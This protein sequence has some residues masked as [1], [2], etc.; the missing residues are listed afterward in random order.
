[1]LAVSMTWRCRE[2]RLIDDGPEPGVIVTTSRSCT[3]LPVADDGTCACAMPCGS[4]AVLVLGAD[5]H[6][7]LLAAFVVV[8][9]LQTADENVQR[10]GDVLHA[11]AEVRGFVAI[12][13]DAE[14]R[15]A[16]DESSCRDRRRRASASL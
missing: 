8:G 6:F 14:L 15:L 2:M 16:G 10:R 4:L 9:D 5:V 3:G 7:V 1:M 13:A 11:H 12:D